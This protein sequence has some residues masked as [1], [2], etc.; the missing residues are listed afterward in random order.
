MGLFMTIDSFRV[1][2]HCPTGQIYFHLQWCFNTPDLFSKVIKKNPKHGPVGKTM[3]IGACKAHGQVPVS[4][5]LRNSSTD[6]IRM[7]HHSLGKLISLLHH[8][9]WHQ[10]VKQWYLIDIDTWTWLFNRPNYLERILIAL[11]KIQIG[12][13]VDMSWYS[14]FS[15]SSGPEGTKSL[16]V[17]LA[18]N[19]TVERLDLDDNGIETQGALY[20][21][22]MLKENYFIV[23]LVGNTVQ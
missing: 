12:S 17:P 22:E 9:L 1:T 21:A 20:M 23:S 11:L 13:W 4:Y 16:C 5:Y 6:T 10:S 2:H 14:L 3:Y 8:T 19:T 18:T 7:R 15:L